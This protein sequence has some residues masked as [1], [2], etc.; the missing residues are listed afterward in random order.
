MFL[1]QELKVRLLKFLLKWALRL[2]CPV[3]LALWQVLLLSSSGA[4]STKGKMQ[5]WVWLFSCLGSKH[6]RFPSNPHQK[7]A[8]ICCWVLASSTAPSGGSKGADCSSGGLAGH[9]RGPKGAAYNVP[10]PSL[11]KVTTISKSTVW[12]RRMEEFTPAVWR[13]ETCMCKSRSSS[14]SWKVLNS[15]TDLDLYVLL[16]VW[17]AQRK[18][19][20]F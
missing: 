5:P 9:R 13:M 15:H 18:P 16:R 17:K 14:G 4:K 12:R 1:L 8:T 7:P 11:E 10:T 6:L 19:L 20:L 3:I 2:C